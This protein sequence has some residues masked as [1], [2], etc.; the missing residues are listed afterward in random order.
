MVLAGALHGVA[1]AQDTFQFT[2]QGSGTHLWNFYECGSAPDPITC[3]NGP[4][5]YITPIGWSGSINITTSDDHDG[6]YSGAEVLSFNMASNLA[7][8]TTDGLGSGLF[9]WGLAVTV[10]DG[11][12]TSINGGGYPY[13]PNVDPYTGIS[14]SGLTASYSFG[15]CHHC[16]V[17]AATAELTPVVTSVPE[18]ETYLMTLAGLAMIGALARWRRPQSGRRTRLAE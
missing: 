15:D 11:R 10:N 3:A 1:V 18:P 5:A 7:S 4:G 14:F 12:V 16:G 6:V 17:Y 13:P 2:F 9:G 8:F